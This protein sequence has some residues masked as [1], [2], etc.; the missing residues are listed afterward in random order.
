M[1]MFKHCVCVFP[2]NTEGVNEWEQFLIR[3]SAWKDTHCER[4]PFSQV[5]ILAA[6]FTWG[7]SG[8]YKTCLE[9]KFH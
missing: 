7:F 9:I 4:N 5:N 6:E 2:L 3:A 1:F 8:L